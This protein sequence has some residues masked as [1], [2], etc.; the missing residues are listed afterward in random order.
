MSTKATIEGYLRD[1]QKKQDWT[2]YLS[3]GLVFTS[4]TNPIRRLSG[5]E[6]FLQSTK[7][8]YTMIKAVEVRDLIVDGD[9]AV[10]LTHYDLEPPQGPVFVSDV[11]EYLACAMARSCRLTFTSTAHPFQSK[12]GGGN[13]MSYDEGLAS[14]VRA[15][16]GRSCPIQKKRMFGGVTFMVRGKMCVS[17]GKDRIMCRID[18]AIHDA[19]STPRLPERGHEGA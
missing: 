7:R 3:D 2:S 1:L 16:L 19:H 10:A 4:Y 11:A 14:R 9:K 5:K 15:A 8:F 13:L 12:V 18:P 17:V 6:A